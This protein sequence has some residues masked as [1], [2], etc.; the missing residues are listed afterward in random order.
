MKSV[1]RK[2]MA[3]CICSGSSS[4]AVLSSTDQALRR[5]TCDRPP[6][7]PRLASCRSDTSHRAS[8]RLPSTP[9]ATG[10]T[11]AEAARPSAR[12]RRESSAHTAH[13]ARVSA[14]Y[15][16]IMS[17]SPL[18]ASSLSAA[19][20]G[21]TRPLQRRGQRRAQRQQ[22]RR[23]RRRPCAQASRERQQGQGAQQQQ[24]H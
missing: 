23:G 22:R 7:R 4:D 2:Q 19:L 8:C 16:H 3:T 6:L 21:V 10:C 12:R 24:H 9:L 5:E 18:P 1:R 20:P 15:A 17:E 11:S 14:A 13:Q